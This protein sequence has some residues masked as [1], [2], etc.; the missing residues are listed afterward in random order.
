M[1][2]AF[3][4]LAEEFDAGLDSQVL[5]TGPSATGDMGSLVRGVHGPQEVHVAIL[6]DR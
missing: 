3:D 5:A 4:R 1:P 6:E 2:A